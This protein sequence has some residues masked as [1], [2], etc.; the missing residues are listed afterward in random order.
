MRDSRRAWAGYV[1]LTRQFARGYSS[2]PMPAWIE[3]NLRILW[4]L[5][6][7]GV[8]VALL[9]VLR[10][11]LTPIFFGFVIAYALDPVI[12]RLERWRI[13]RTGGILIVLA[14]LLAGTAVFAL[15]VVPE[16][17]AEVG[18]LVRASRVA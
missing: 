2:R 11:V 4:Y 6:V 12:D 16:I 1:D 8:A 17:L 14:V 15:I 5:L 7:G 13:P 9:Y 3:R 18:E 10:G